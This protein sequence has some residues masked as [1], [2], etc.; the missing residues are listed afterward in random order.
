MEAYD[1]YNKCI[2][3]WLR[4]FLICSGCDVLDENFQVNAMTC[5]M[6]IINLIAQV[7]C[8]HTLYYGTMLE[9]IFC[10]TISSIA[11]QVC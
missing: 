10:M 4:P 1:R 6:Y 2:F 7:M 8:I 3:K 9:K 5:V 11:A